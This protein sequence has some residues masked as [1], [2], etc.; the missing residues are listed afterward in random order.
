VL[1]EAKGPGYANKFTRELAPKQWFAKGARSLVD[2]A[3]RQS[4]AAK[5][6]PIQWHVAESKAAEAIREL[7]NNARVHGIEVVHTPVL[8]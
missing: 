7:L 4:K 2:Q 1:L 5:G 8:P 6:V 3:V